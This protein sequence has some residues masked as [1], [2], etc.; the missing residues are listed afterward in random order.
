MA[1]LS[2]LFVASMV[3]VCSAASGGLRGSQEDVR[4]T[5]HSFGS[6]ILL[7]VLRSRRSFGKQVLELNYDSAP[8]S[9]PSSDCDAYMDHFAQAVCAARNYLTQPNGEPCSQSDQEEAKQVIF[10]GNH[11]TF[12]N[13]VTKPG[14][15]RN[16]GGMWWEF[17]RVEPQ[18]TEYL[19]ELEIVTNAT[20]KYDDNMAAL[21]DYANPS[22]PGNQGDIMAPFCPEEKWDNWWSVWS[23]SFTLVNTE[24]L[25]NDFYKNEHWQR[26]NTA[27]I[28]V[29]LQA[30]PDCL[31]HGEGAEEPLESSFF[32][33]V[34][35]PQMVEWAREKNV[36]NPPLKLYS[37][38][39]NCQDVLDVFEKQYP[40]WVTGQEDGVTCTY[41][42]EGW[43]KCMLEDPLA[44]ANCGGSGYPPVSC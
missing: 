38:S 6:N 12:L 22:W 34:E 40:D 10:E 42:P 41:C 27:M 36:S 11:T 7:Q 33:S 28:N 24:A 17:G 30:N 21:W 44:Y 20:C 32:Y 1:A 19:K 23:K 5:E 43:A 15:C 16:T 18:F 2:T 35:V 26:P 37:I 3:A 13:P 39:D 29:C 8:A 14:K 31:P 25:Y 9:P 4:F